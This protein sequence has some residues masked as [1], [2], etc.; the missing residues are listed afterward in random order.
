M[1]GFSYWQVGVVVPDIEAAMDELAS[2]LGVD[3]SGPKPRDVGQW[4]LRIAFTRQGPPDV[5]LIGGPPDPIWDAGG[6]ARLHHVGTWTSDM[7][8]DAA[9][10]EAAGFELALDGAPHG[11]S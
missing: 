8:A 5:E 1:H 3:W 9:R 4:G 6:G 11:G 2:G 10:L 7:A